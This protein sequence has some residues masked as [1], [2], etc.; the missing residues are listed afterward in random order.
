MSHLL[1]IQ[2]V[3]KS[4]RLR[5]PLA[6]A[7]R[8]PFRFQSRAVL[9]GCTLWMDE[10]E[11]LA[12]VGPNGAG[13]STLARIVMGTV[14]PDRGKATLS[15]ADLSLPAARALVAMARPDDPTFHPRI[16]VREAI[17]FHLALRN[18]GDVEERIGAL[19][20]PSSNHPG[21]GNDPLKVRGLLDSR[22]ATLSAGE[23][24][25]ASLFAALL[26]RP[27]LLV[28]DEISRV[29]DP[30]MG[31][32]VRALLAHESTRGTAILSITHDLDEARESDRVALMVDGA[33]AACGRWDE[34]RSPVSAAFGLSPDIPGD[35]E[36]KARTGHGAAAE[37]PLEG[38][39]DQGIEGGASNHPQKTAPAHA[40]GASSIEGPAGSTGGVP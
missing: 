23:K 18:I 8:H 14:L 32:A 20:S 12:L 39:A 10:G 36:N 27:R 17:R 15:G 1:T 40:S 34:V 22:G 3:H 5:R 35:P 30:A 25:R 6:T 16:T 33:I 13:K 28:L 29:L 38:D 4:F 24:A 9:S 31:K 7:L 19:L 37:S 11:R 21:Q 2:D 26:A